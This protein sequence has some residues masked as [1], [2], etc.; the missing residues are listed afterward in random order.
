MILKK[1]DSFRWTEEAQKAPDELKVLITKFSVLVV[2]HEE[3][4]S[5]M[6]WQQLWSLVWSSW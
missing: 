4:S 6:S 5:T 2:E 3:P 1:S